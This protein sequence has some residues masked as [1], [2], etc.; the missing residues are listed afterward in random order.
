V[1][2]VGLRILLS[3]LKYLFSV[4]VTIL[5]KLYDDGDH[6]AVLC[7]TWSPKF[8]KTRGTANK[9]FFRERNCKLIRVN[10]AVVRLVQQTSWPRKWWMCG[11]I[12]RGPTTNDAICGVSA[13]SCKHF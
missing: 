13:S 1:T 3:V 6:C 7:M 8:L 10:G 9:H 2:H 11:W 5:S 4:Y 12:G